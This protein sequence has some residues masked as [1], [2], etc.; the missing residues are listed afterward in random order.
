M[1]RILRPDAFT[2]LGNE[3]AKK[4]FARYFRVLRG[5]VPPRFQICKRIPASFEPSWETEEL[6]KIHDLS[7]RE[8]KKTLELVD[9][10]KM[11][12]DELEK[13]KS[14]LL[15]LKIELARRLLSSCQLCEHKCGVNRLKGEKGFCR[16]GKTKV[17]SEFMHY[18]EE[19]VLVPSYTV[20]F[21]GC[22]FK[23]CFCQNWD[24]SQFP[25][26]GEEFSPA[27]LSFLISEA[28]KHGARNVNFVGGNPDPH[29][30]FIL[31]TL[32][33]Y[34]GRLSSV[35]NSNMYYSSSSAEL[36]KGTQDIYLTDFKWGNDR[37]ARKYSGISRYWETV[38]RNHLTAFSDAELIIRH[39]V[40]PG[41]LECCTFPVLRWIAENLGEKV[42]VNVMAQYRP[43][44]RAA[45]YP[46]INRALSPQEFRK[47][48]EEAERLG[49]SLEP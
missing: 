37:C 47:A 9:K 16:V 11:K 44:Y 29:L 22:S 24:I 38:T 34:G 43:C 5:E 15:D 35:W 13:P 25:D 30:L 36:L 41:H 7:L 12:L 46:E 6:W 33:E 10:G 32:R 40:M 21:S 48:L 31:E 2:V 45:E 23:C 27:E 26:E 28:E 14:S 4:S 1:W 8:F 19:S 42:W 39:L 49:L 3:R 17:A 20:F 18:G